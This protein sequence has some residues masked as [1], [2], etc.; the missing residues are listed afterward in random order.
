MVAA[1]LLRALRV[2]R[3]KSFGLAAFRGL[4]IAFDLCPLASEPERM[5]KRLRRLRNLPGMRALLHET[6]FQVS[7]LIQPLF[8]VE[9]SEVRNEIASMPGICQLSVD[10][11]ELEAKE[12]ASLGIPA[13]LLFGIPDRKDELGSGA[14]DDD[15]IV[16]LAVHTLKRSVPQLLVITDICLCEY[17][18]HGHCGVLQGQRILNDPTVELLAKTAVSHARAGADVVAPSDMM[19][20]R[21]ATIRRELDQAGF[22]ELPIMSYSSKFASCFYGPFRE[23]AQSTPAFGDRKTHQLNPA[24]AREAIAESLADLEEGADILLVK[25][26]LCYLDIIQRVRQLTTL[27]IAAYN[28]SGEYSMVKAAASKGWLDEARAVWEMLV[29]IKRA[30]ADM[31][32]TYF[33]KDIASGRLKYRY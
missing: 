32:I 25:P 14:Y 22:P 17:T 6:Q 8:V 10:Q 30:G 18:S 29:S 11:L 19:D 5:N 26:A 15:G 16:Q 3:G 31:I 28:V 21:V 9:G 4:K 2:L 27:P 33:A 7:D 20:L 13:V 24:N 23:A 12:L 1:M